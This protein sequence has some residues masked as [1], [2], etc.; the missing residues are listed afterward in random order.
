MNDPINDGDAPGSAPRM[1]RRQF[2][3]V[4]GIG[5]AGGA[6]L[7]A[8]GWGAASAWISWMP[9]AALVRSSFAPHLGDTFAARA[10]SSSSVAVRLVDIRDLRAGALD[11]AH[12]QPGVD[13]EHNFLLS[14]RGPLDQPLAQGTY[15][16]AHDR[17]G[18]FALFIVPMAPE[19][20]AR[21]Y[22]SIFNRQQA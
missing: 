2:L 15:E 10:G 7:A 5:L 9:P 3:K 17:F 21:Y 6:L 8:G 18:S 16:F 11:S 22:E 1:P 19:Q 4:A 13:G 20:D 14:F 12:T